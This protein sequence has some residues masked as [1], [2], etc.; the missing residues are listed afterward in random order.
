MERR[1]SERKPAAYLT[2]RAWFAG[3]EFYVNEDVL[4]PRSPLAELVVAI[5]RTD[6]R[7]EVTPTAETV[8]REGDVLIV[9][10]EPARVRTFNKAMRQRR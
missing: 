1:V 7:M 4:V 3:L 6:G 10:G 5:R 8:V 2:N 9:I